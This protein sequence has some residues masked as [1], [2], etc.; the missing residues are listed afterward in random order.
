M[1]RT[2]VGVG[3]GD[4]KSDLFVARCTYFADSAASMQPWRNFPSLPDGD[5]SGTMTRCVGR[6]WPASAG[7]PSLGCG[8][9]VAVPAAPLVERQGPCPDAGTGH[10]Q[11]PLP[12]GREAARI[13]R[14]A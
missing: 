11:D 10:G 4:P 7:G 14:R 3:L 1:M 12:E 8:T 6:P 9:G 5:L 13:H 2:C